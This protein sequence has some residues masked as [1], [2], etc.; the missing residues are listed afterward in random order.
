MTPCSV[1]VDNDVSENLAV[2][3]FRMK[4]STTPWRYIWEVDV[5]STHSYS[6]H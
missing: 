4:R 3:V 5:S 1:A 2:S 6:L